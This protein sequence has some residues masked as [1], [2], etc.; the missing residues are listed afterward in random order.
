[1]Y[2]FSPISY[3]S[4]F[5]CNLLVAIGRLGIFHN[6]ITKIITICPK[7]AT[8]QRNSGPVNAHLTSDLKNCF[9]DGFYKL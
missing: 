6:I 5:Q 1:M 4:I 2:F 8:D 7:V 3:C 9:E